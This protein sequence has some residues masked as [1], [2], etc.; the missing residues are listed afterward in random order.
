MGVSAQAAAQMHKRMPGGE[1]LIVSGDIFEGEVPQIG[2]ELW[3]VPFDGWGT[4]HD[5]VAPRRVVARR[6]TVISSD[7]QVLA[8]EAL[9]GGPRSL[10]IA[11]VLHLRVVAPAA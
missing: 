10:L 5:L 9:P 1:Q 4:E 8:D 11:D 6:Y 2:T 7:G 3:R